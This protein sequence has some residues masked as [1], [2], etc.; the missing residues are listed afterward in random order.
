MVQL[1]VYIAYLIGIM[2]VLAY[3]LLIVV[4]RLIWELIW[5]WYKKKKKAG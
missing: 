1:L 2:I 5:E 3:G 4:V